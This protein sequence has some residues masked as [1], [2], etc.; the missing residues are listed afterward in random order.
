MYLLVKVEADEAHYAQIHHKRRNAV[1]EHVDDPSKDEV[2]PNMPQVSE[3]FWEYQCSVWVF[4]KHFSVSTIQVFLHAFVCGR[5]QYCK[6]CQCSNQHHATIDASHDTTA[7]TP[8]REKNIREFIGCNVGHAYLVKD[9]H[10]EGIHQSRKFSENRKLPRSGVNMMPLVIY[11]PHLLFQSFEIVV[12]FSPLTLPNGNQNH[13]LIHRTT[14]YTCRIAFVVQQYSYVDE[15]IRSV[16]SLPW[17][18]LPELRIPKVRKP[19]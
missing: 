5:V 13:L 15:S 19:F 8:G 2:V 9:N 11:H 4:G 18:T 14:V 10:L 6:V 7:N 1:G 3:L 17:L 16:R 12:L